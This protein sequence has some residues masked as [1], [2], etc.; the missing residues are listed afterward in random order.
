MCALYVG[1]FLTLFITRAWSIAIAEVVSSH[2]EV[3]VKK[4]TQKKAVSVIVDNKNIHIIVKYILL[5]LILMDRKNYSQVPQR[6]I[7]IPLLS[8]LLL[9]ISLVLIIAKYMMSD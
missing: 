7:H 1:W 5:Q 8:S 2:S 3:H 9:I 6:N 4:P